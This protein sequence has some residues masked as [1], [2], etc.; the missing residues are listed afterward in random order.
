[1]GNRVR[2]TERWWKVG[3]TSLLVATGLLSGVLVGAAANPTRTEAVI[4]ARPGQ[5]AAAE[6]AVRADGGHITSE[7]AALNSITAVIDRADLAAVAASPA[8]AS[9]TPDANLD[10]VSDSAGYNS[11]SDPYSLAS[12]ES[13]TGVRSLWAN[14]TGAG[15]GVALIDSG[16]T[17]VPGLLD[18]VV[19]GPNFSSSSNDTDNFGH[20]T[21]LAGIIAGDQHNADPVANAANTADYF[22]VA[23]SS[24]LVSVKVADDSGNT[25][26]SQLL[27]GIDW[28]IANQATYNFRVI[29]LSFGAAPQD[30]Y[31]N[32]PLAWAVEQAWQ[33]GIVVVVSAGNNG[34]NSGGLEDPA[35]DPFVIAVGAEDTDGNS[36]N[37]SV[38]SFSNWGDGTRNPDFVAP[39]V[40]MQGVADPGSYVDRT[41]ASTGAI[42]PQFFRGSGTSEAAAYT[43]GL[44]ALL[45]QEHPSFT[46]DQIKALLVGSAQPIAGTDPRAQ[47][48]GAV[49]PS[50]A[51]GPLTPSLAAAIA[52]PQSF[53]QAAPPATSGTQSGTQSGTPAPTFTTQGR[54]L[55]GTNLSGANLAGADLQGDNL[56]G[57]N[58]DFANLAGV[59]LAGADLQ[60]A[61]LTGANLAGADL[62]GANLQSTDLASAYLQ[63]ANLQATNL[64]NAN[65]PGAVVSGA[66]ITGA[67]ATQFLKTTS[68]GGETSG[69]GQGS[70]SA[71]TSAPPGSTSSGSSWSGSSWSGSSWSGSSWSGSSWSGSSWSGSSWSGSSWSG[72]SWS[73]ATWS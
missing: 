37:P 61:D 15:V 4:V 33:A 48:A 38:A 46:P 17:Q 66:N 25:N 63:A 73:T 10:L 23:P 11:S 70:A 43:S 68:E 35:Y 2:T 42:T 13:S 58:L 60:G 30:A 55:S 72:S 56:Q 22:G 27:Q 8:I 7:L 36:G 40:H 47:G 26:L 51:A 71:G 5:L 62:Q 18:Q 69:V 41:F 12:I 21:F 20:G 24:T 67:G 52:T 39:G 59:N 64:R 1:M 44:V 50:A 28:V 65:G 32:D 14:E 9:A 54:N 53:P 31:V 57:A 49:D 45:V 34:A 19:Q 6:R 3:A 16:V 29:N